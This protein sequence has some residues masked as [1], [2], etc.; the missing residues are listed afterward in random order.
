MKRRCVASM[1]AA[2]VGALIC[3]GLA[4]P[5]VAGAGTA[6]EVATAME[7]TSPE[8]AAGRT[9][10]SPPAQ[11]K[12]PREPAT[13]DAP[14]QNQK[15]PDQAKA[16]RRPFEPEGPAPGRGGKRIGAAPAPRGCTGAV[17]TT[18]ASGATQNKNKYGAGE[19]VYLNG[20]NFPAG[21]T[22]TYTIS[23]V[24][25]KAA[26][27]FPSGTF[28]PGTG[29]FT[30]RLIWPTPAETGHEYK[31]VVS[32]TGG[33]GQSCRKS[34]N[35]FFV[36]SEQEQPRVGAK[37]AGCPLRL[38]TRR[39]FERGRTTI[40]AYAVN[41]D[42]AAAAGTTVVLRGPGVDERALTDA[43][44]FVQF[45][46]KSRRGGRFQ[47]TVPGICRAP[48]TV[49]TTDKAAAVGAFTA[50]GIRINRSA[51]NETG[52]SVT[53][54]SLTVAK[55]TIVTVRVEL[56]GQPVVNGIVTLNGPGVRAVG[57]TGA[58]G[59]VR[60]RVTPSRA[61]VLHVGVPNVTNRVKRFGVLGVVASG[62][63]LAG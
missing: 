19:S 6:E 14:G 62:R 56:F 18:D 38:T 42:G 3:V 63:G 23:K 5:S 17:W 33:N 10:P 52:I 16:P 2:T 8:R 53:P 13:P 24:N 34:D 43:N 25:D 41:P 9:P 4:A 59:G 36:G 44:G 58:N 20:R 55:E 45:N 1:R 7:A 11:A 50:N 57:R 39:V 28:T 31:V 48:V 22:L 60:V 49:A 47:V 54:R 32:F 61:G 12:P 35:F 30:A 21:A 27:G 40:G 29:D 46:L 26:T 37:E 15:A 51:V